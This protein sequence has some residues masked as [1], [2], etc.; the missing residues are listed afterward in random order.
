MRRPSPSS[1]SLTLFS[2]NLLLLLLPLGQSGP[3]SQPAQEPAGV[4]L[5]GFPFVCRERCQVR[6]DSQFAAS[7]YLEESRST[8]K[9]GRSTL[10][11]ATPQELE[12]MHRRIYLGE[13]LQELQ[14]KLPASLGEGQVLGG[15]YRKRGGGDTLA[16]FFV[17]EK[18]AHFATFSRDGGGQADWKDFLAAL[19]LFGA[20]VST[21][22]RTCP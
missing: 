9:F 16:V 14:G 1:H 2:V 12:R 6:E 15:R 13:K 7:V 17:F 4:R 11:S 5:K 8:L 3:E 20:P 19:G 22:C 10:A 21:S 18:A